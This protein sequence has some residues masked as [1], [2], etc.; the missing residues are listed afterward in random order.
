MAVACAREPA[1]SRSM[2]FGKCRFQTMSPKLVF[3]IHARREKAKSTQQ[4]LCMLRKAIHLAQTVGA[5]LG[6]REILQ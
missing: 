2:G 5:G 1:K 6:K 4:S 3:P